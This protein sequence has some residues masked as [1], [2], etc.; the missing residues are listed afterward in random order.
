MWNR[1]GAKLEI[2]QFKECEHDADD[3]RTRDDQKNLLQFR[4]CSSL[5]WF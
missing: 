5:P 3:M 4:L 2:L 1:G